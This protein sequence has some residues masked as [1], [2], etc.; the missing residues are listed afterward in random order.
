MKKLLVLSIVVNIVF[1]IL[2]IAN[3][4]TVLQVD[5]DC[6]DEQCA[7]PPCCNG[8]VNGDAKIDLADA[9]SLLT[10]LF[11]DGDEPLAIASS[12]VTGSSLITATGQTMCYDGV[13]VLVDCAST[14]YPGQDGAYQKGCAMEGRFVDNSDGTVTDIC[15][16]LM[17]QQEKEPGDS[18]WMGALQYCDELEFAGH[19]DWRLPNVRELQSIVDYGRHSPSIDPVFSEESLW[20]WSSTTGNGSTDSAWSMHFDD[21]RVILNFKH[22][23]CFVR[24]VRDAQ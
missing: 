2:F 6:V 15:T 12:G 7:D 10:Y 21:G 17:W 20:Y 18:A 4:G 24:A 14:R 3:T 16:G 1:A 13:S 9:I 19:D 8:D 22:I 5:A 23:R 11:S